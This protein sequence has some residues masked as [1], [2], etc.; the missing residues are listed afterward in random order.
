[1]TS[2]A[3]NIQYPTAYNGSESVSVA[4]GNTVPIQNYGQGLLPLPDS[5][6][7]LLYVDDILI[8]GNQPEHIN[9][10]L[11]DLHTQFALK[12]LGEINLFLGIQINRT[13][14]GFFL[15]QAHYASKLLQETG[16]MDCK[17]CPT[18]ATPAGRHP[19][20]LD[21]PFHDPTHYRR[22]A[23]SL[24]YLT[25][26]SPDIAYA[27]NQVCQHMQNSTN[28]DFSQLKR[29]LRYIKGTQ[30]HGL[31]IVAGDTTLQTYADADWAADI[32]DRKSISGHC[33]FM[34]SNLISWSVKKQVTVAKSS[35]EAEYR[36][37]SA[38]TSEIIWLRRLASELQLFQSSP[39]VLHCDNISAIAIAKNLVFHART[40]HIEIDYQFIR[41][42]IA[43]RSIQIQHISS[44][45]QIADILTKP[46]VQTRFELLRSKLT[47]HSPNT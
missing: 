12:Q 17:P 4:N 3:S 30:S 28:A 29:I 13:N 2:D 27:T 15:T 11:S 8:T 37:L 35:T 7:I 1:M 33:T 44:Q 45:A 24:Q 10:L 18:P 41:Q 25:I 42:H 32:S 19:Q 6:R 31:P 40:K 39:T 34:G 36:A 9:K 5:S 47:V 14:S 22:I 38:A 43:N 20:Q 23:G 21:E 46:F 16:F 26:T